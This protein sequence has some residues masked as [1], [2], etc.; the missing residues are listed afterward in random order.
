MVLVPGYTDLAEATAAN[1]YTEWERARFHEYHEH[2]ATMMQDCYAQQSAGTDMPYW[3]QQQQSFGS[4]SS[5]MC[6]SSSTD[7][8]CIALSACHRLLL[9]WVSRIVL[10]N[11]AEAVRRSEPVTPESPG[12]GLHDNVEW[13]AA[14]KTVD[15]MAHVVSHCLHPE[16]GIFGMQLTILP[17]RIIYLFASRHGLLE[18]QEW[19]H[20]VADDL[21]ARNY[22]I[23]SWSVLGPKQMSD[24]TDSSCVFV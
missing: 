18:R 17:L 23:A 12:Q 16:N 7:A 21:L 10:Y 9:M 22:R 14:L 1:P 24:Y 5:D 6:G 4:T 15:D 3:V 19:C 13:F 2:L 11:G 20:G 8:P